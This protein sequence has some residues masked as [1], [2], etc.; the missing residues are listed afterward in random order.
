MGKRYLQRLNEKFQG[1]RREE[2]VDAGQEC[3][4][5]TTGETSCRHEREQGAEGER[6]EA[7]QQQLEGRQGNAS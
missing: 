6:D 3:R 5:K 1:S 7:Q 4:E 2:N